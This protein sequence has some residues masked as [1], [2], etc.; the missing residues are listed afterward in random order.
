MWFAFENPY[1]GSAPVT[2]PIQCQFPVEY[3]NVE[4]LAKNEKIMPF[5]FFSR[6]KNTDKPFVLSHM[7]RF[8]KLP[9]F[10]K[11]KI[12]YLQSVGRRWVHTSSSNSSKTLALHPVLP[13]MYKSTS[14]RLAF[15]TEPFNWITLF[16]FVQQAEKFFP[17]TNISHIYTSEVPAAISQL[18][19]STPTAFIISQQEH[20]LRTVFSPLAALGARIITLIFSTV[21][22][23]KIKQAFPDVSIDFSGSS[24]IHQGLIGL[25]QKANP[26]GSCSNLILCVP[27]ETYQTKINSYTRMLYCFYTILI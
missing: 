24:C 21:Y 26:K 23:N 3:A 1:Y 25:D 8:Q 9:L 5:R 16:R 17:S 14:A 11:L 18:A 2:R 6:S 15:I 20:N 13:T 4:L 10:R 22:T 12:L 19:P 7:P 27:N